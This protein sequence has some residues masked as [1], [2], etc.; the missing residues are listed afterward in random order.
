VAKHSPISASTAHRWF[1]CPG[2]VELS[3][4]APPQKQ[5]VYALQGSA[6]HWVIEQIL[7]TDKPID[8]YSFVGKIYKDEDLEYEIQEDDIDSCLVFVELI[9]EVRGSAKYILHSEAKLDLSCIYPVLA[10]TADAILIE[11]NLKRLK[12]Y[13]YKHGSGVPVNVENNKQLLYYA[14]GAINYVCDKHKIDYLSVLGWGQTFKEVEISIVQPRCRHKDGAVRSW[15][16]PS[17]VLDAFAA[18]L[19]EKAAATADKKAPLVTGSHCRFC[20]ALAICPAFTNQTFEL[21]QADFKA[22][23][24]PVNLN[25]P[26]PQALTKPEIAKILN[27][28]DMISEWLKAV[29]AHALSVMEHGEEMPGFKLV[30]KRSNRKWIDESETAAT[31]SMVLQ[32]EEMYKK[33]LLSPAQMEKTLGKKRKGMIETLVMVPESG[34]TIAPEHD[35]REPVKGSAVA[36]FETNEQ[37]KER[38]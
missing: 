29:E 26:A 8:I 2:S 20:P 28:A 37:R 32:D 3:K 14:L 18:E 12:V 23:S 34:N 13:D 30:K 36:D 24:S 7:K 4:S 15:V 5:S 22:V 33:S 6:A 10:G 35:P 27:F 17:D 9:N 1:A 21:A 38:T 19:K 25:L 16:V 31:L 11:S